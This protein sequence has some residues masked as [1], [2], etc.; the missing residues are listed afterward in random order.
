[1]D[2]QGREVWLEPRKCPQLCIPDPGEPQLLSRVAQL[3]KVTANSVPWA[4]ITLYHTEGAF[5]G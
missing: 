1:V 5:R 2:E 4:G 3:C